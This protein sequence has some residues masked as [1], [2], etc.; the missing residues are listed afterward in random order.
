MEFDYVNFLNGT[1]DGL[2][3][4]GIFAANL[5]DIGPINL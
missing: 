4:V 2:G 3:R 1:T 5:W